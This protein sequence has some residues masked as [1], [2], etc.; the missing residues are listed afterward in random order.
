MMTRRHKIVTGLQ[1]AIAYAKG[2]GAEVRLTRYNVPEN[3]DVKKLR[4]GLGMSQPEFALRFGFSLGTLRQWEQGRR[5]PDGA[6]RVL[7]T[8]IKRSPNAVKKALE[9]G[10]ERRAARA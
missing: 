5:Y 10:P 1:E 6:A 8:V 2:N 9:Q 4:E 7:L 3:I